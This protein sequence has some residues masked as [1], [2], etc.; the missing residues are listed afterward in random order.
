MRGYDELRALLAEQRP[1][2]P[3]RVAE[4]S[5]AA[6]QLL[7]VALA[8]KASGV[9]PPEFVATLLDTQFVLTAPLV[10]AITAPLLGTTATEHQ[11]ATL[12]PVL[13]QR[14]PLFTD[15]SKQLLC[16]AVVNVICSAQVRSSIA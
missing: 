4:A 10:E 5:C 7:L 16:D 14:I 6:I 11:V 1:L 8:D 9:L 15:P 2:E 3:L 12:L 13:L